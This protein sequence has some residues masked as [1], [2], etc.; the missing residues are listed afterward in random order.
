MA[1]AKLRPSTT[2]IKY[3]GKQKPPMQWQ[4]TSQLHSKSRD[5]K[6]KKL[7]S[8]APRRSSPIMRSKKA[9]LSVSP[10]TEG[11]LNTRHKIRKIVT[12]QVAK[13]KKDA[14]TNQPYKH[15]Q[16]TSV[17]VQLQRKTAKTLKSGKAGKTAN[18]AMTGKSVKALRKHKRKIQ[19]T[20]PK[21]AGTPVLF[22]VKD[23]PKRKTHHHQ[24]QLKQLRRDQ[25][26]HQQ[27]HEQQQL[28][29]HK[30][31]NQQRQ[32][33]QLRGALYE[34]NPRSMPPRSQPH[35][36]MEFFSNM[37]QRLPKTLPPRDT[38]MS[39]VEPFVCDAEMQQRQ[40]LQVPLSSRLPI[41]DF[42]STQEFQ[43]MRMAS[44]RP[45]FV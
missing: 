32:L 29:L 19:H 5:P 4:A 27:E 43:N 17:G 25:Q 8:K 42:I 34:R 11:I 20:D 9:P 7:P 37:G 44:K 18:T 36:V 15:Q 45:R 2:K 12:S 22:L 14:W 21:T 41:I 3:L 16:L 10:L 24:L 40:R 28:K 1:R 39:P 6:K 23:T 31:Q 26:Q 35:N 30:L 38:R 13:K 33:D